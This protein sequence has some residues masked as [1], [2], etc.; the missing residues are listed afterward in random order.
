MALLD[1]SLGAGGIAKLW[2]LAVGPAKE[3]PFD[4]QNEIIPAALLLGSPPPLPLL[5]VGHGWWEGFLTVSKKETREHVNERQTWER[6]EES[7]VGL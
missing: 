3:L 4:Q 2:E 1:L 6:Q 7:F 5:T